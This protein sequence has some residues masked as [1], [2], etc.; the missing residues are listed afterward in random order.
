MTYAYQFLSILNSLLLVVVLVFLLRGSFRKFWVLLV[1][2]AW[3]LIANA[4]LTVLSLLYHGSDLV[5]GATTEAQRLYARLYWT[6]DVVVDLLRFLL[7][8]VLTHKAT[9]ETR[10]VGVGRVLGGVAAA[11]VVLPFLLFDPSFRPDSNWPRSAW[12]NS[13]SELLNFGAAVMNLVLWGT[14]IASRRRGPQLLTVSAGLGVVVTGAAIAYG[15]RHFIPPG[16][17]R[18]VPNLFLMLTQ[19][20]GFAIWCRAFWPAPKPRQAPGDALPGRV[21][22]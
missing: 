2:V 4:T 1:Y 15:L 22:Y 7:V 19:L 17:F 3:E 5:T 14:L 16:T 8:I 20:A 10:R 9:S 12:F 13:T 11:A 6:N 21:G 18:S